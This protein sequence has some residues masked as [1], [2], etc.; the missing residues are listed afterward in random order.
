M[1]NLLGKHHSYDAMYD[2]AQRFSQD[3]SYW[4]EWIN[5]D[6]ARIRNNKTNS[7]I[8]KVWDNDFKTVFYHVVDISR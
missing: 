6:M 2:T 3:G 8:L 4:S 5:G 7:P 1:R